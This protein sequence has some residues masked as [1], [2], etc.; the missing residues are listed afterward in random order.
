MAIEPA[1]AVRQLPDGVY[2]RL[3][4]TPYFAQDRLG[5]SDLIR[6]HRFR[7][8]WWWSS[9]WNPLRVQ[10][11]TDAQNYGSALHKIMLEGRHAYEAAFVV[12]PDKRHY[13]GLLVTTEDIKAAL[14]KARVSTLKTTGW[15]KENW[16]EAAALHLPEQHVWDNIW[17]DFNASRT[18]LAPDGV[19][20][21]GL[22]PGVSHT[23]DAMLRL[24]LEIALEDPD[25]RNIL[26]EDNDVPHLAEL[27]YF[28]TDDEGVRRRARFDDPLPVTTL[29][30]KSL[31]DWRGREIKHMIADR[32]L[33]DGLDIQVGD[34]H[35][36]RQRMFA[37]IRAEGFA[38]IHGGS[39]QEQAWLVAMAER[40]IKWDWTWLFYQKPELSGKAPIIF[41]LREAWAGAYHK[42]GFRK[43]RRARDFYLECIEH[44]GLGPV[45]SI[46]G[47]PSR[48]WGASMPVHY[49]DDRRVPSITPPRAYQAFDE[50][51]VDGEEAHFTR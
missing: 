51:P 6:L 28:W 36:A 8:G 37:Q 50:M 43:A 4:E 49:T 22:T 13:P 42:S 48:P 40:S 23:E 5:S 47:R 27:S 15:V 17:A 25:V 9:R 24:M 20:P 45:C 10:G 44:F 31:G 26:G 34:Q 21:V 30:L 18:I 29:D 32:I 2:I 46:D 7:E 41:P 16:C 35:D 11:Q 3:H 33:A 14:L 38:C 19:T 1:L 12:E 39:D